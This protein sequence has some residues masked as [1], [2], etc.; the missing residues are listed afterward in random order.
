MASKDKTLSRLFMG[1]RTKKIVDWIDAY[2]HLV[3]MDIK[4]CELS[5]NERQ[6]NK[7]KRYREISDWYHE[8][9]KEL[10]NDIP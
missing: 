8:R 3:D 7:A 5:I 6:I 1:K 2:S 10:I 4:Y 9:I